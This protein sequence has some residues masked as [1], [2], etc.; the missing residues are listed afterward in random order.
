MDH[1]STREWIPDLMDGM[2][3]NELKE[4]GGKEWMDWNGMFFKIYL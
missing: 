2:E 3:E 4:N 1:E